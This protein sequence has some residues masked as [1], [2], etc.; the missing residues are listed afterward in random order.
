MESLHTTNEDSKSY[1]K[2]KVA[3]EVLYVSGWIGV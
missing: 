1:V 2:M 3:V